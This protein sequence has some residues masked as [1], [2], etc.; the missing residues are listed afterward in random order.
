MPIIIWATKRWHINDFSIISHNTQIEKF[1]NKIG[2]KHIFIPKNSDK[3]FRGLKLYK[4]YIIQLSSKIKNSNVFFGH[5]SHDYWG[6][7]LMYLLKS[8]G[9]NVYYS[10]QMKEHPRISIFKLMLNSKGR[11]LLL[12][13]IILFLVTK[14]VFN[15]LGFE[16]YYFLGINVKRIRKTFTIHNIS[17]NNKLFQTNKN[18]IR[19]IYNISEVKYILIDQG[20]SFYSY[21]EEL[22][23]TLINFSN[24]NNKLFLKQHP[25]L[26]TKN[27]TL[28]ESLTE[29][30]K[31]VPIEL[32]DNNC[33]F[34]GIAS[35]ALKNHERTVSLLNL[36][37][38][39]KNKHKIYKSFLEN[40]PIKFPSSIEEL[41]IVFSGFS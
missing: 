13:K 17:E 18:L 28:L 14:R 20:E 32:I 35:N 38:I 37:M 33:V 12:D 6:L 21:S 36:V 11:R 23:N 40:H 2:I 30:P 10:S 9:N 7:H 4:S 34:I 26:P 25:T 29:I 8:N 27:R 39:D 15:I 41:D 31:E 22:I 19:S 24:K 1:C 3:S 5:N 16:D